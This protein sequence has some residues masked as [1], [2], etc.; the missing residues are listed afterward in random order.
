VLDGAL[1]VVAELAQLAGRALQL[2]AADGER[3]VDVVAAA[4]AELL[5]ARRPQPQPRLVTA[6]QPDAVVLLAERRQVQDLPVPGRTR[7]GAAGRVFR[8]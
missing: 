7:R 5:L 4:I 3:E 8:A 1:V 2:V 6:A